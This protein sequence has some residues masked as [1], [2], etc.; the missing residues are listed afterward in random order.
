MNDLGLLLYFKIHG[1]AAFPGQGVNQE[2]L[3]MSG[4]PHFDIGGIIH[5][6]VNNQVGF[7]TPGD[8][9]R[10]TRYCSDLAKTI[11]AP[12]FHV[13]GDDP[14]VCVEYFTNFKS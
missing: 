2:C 12:V 10:G 1:D 11:N 7:T 6:I 8:R 9:C 5:L 13:N 3:T 14:E 4:V